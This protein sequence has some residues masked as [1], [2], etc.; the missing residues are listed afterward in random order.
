MNTY[1]AVMRI[2]GDAITFTIPDL[3]GFYV[4][5]DDTD[6]QAAIAEARD[7]LGDF[8]GVWLEEGRDLPPSTPMEA[9]ADLAQANPGAAIVPLRAWPVAGEPK[10]VNISLDSLALAEIDRAAEARGLTRSAYLALA[11]REL[12]SV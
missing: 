7:V 12:E 4:Q 2:E 3:Q 1:L 11:A 10:R 8:C 9:L 5:A 6:I